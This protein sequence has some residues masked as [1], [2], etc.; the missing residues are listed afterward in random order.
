MTCPPE[1]ELL[2]EDDLRFS[3]P[4]WELVYGSDEETAIEKWAKLYDQNGDYSIVQSGEG[5]IVYIRKPA[6]E[7]LIGPTPAQR[8]EVCGESVPHYTANRAEEKT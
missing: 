6:D 2:Q 4:V 7:D 3:L 5:Y 8:W 1:W